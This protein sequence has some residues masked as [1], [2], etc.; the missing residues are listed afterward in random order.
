MGGVKE[1]KSKNHLAKTGFEK[2][3]EGVGGQRGKVMI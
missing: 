3:R 2:G 1:E